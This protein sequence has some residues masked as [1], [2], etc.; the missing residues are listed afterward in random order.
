MVVD[1]EQQARYWSDSDDAHFRWQTRSG[2]FSDTERDL[3]LAAD[4]PTSGRLLEIGCGEGGNL[5]HLGARPGWLGI[6]FSPAK[7]QLAAAALPD[8]AF[9]R[10]DASHLPAADGSFDAVLI[11]D[12]LHHVPDRMAVVR[13]AA[14]V[15]R[16]GGTLGVIEPN[17]LCPL[18]TAQALLIPAERAALSSNAGLIEAE[19]SRAGLLDISLTRAQ[20]FPIARVV[21]H[22]AL[23]LAALSQRPT[24]AR[25]L[26]LTDTLLSRLIPKVA[27]MYLVLRARKA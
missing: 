20:P 2:Y 14:R 24:V 19:L 1:R 8:V 18:V 23:G 11:R 22:P 7:L 4:L 5:Y 3:V 17:G 10:A 21:T 26:T 9:A 15:L 16:P 27:W 12:L 13:E 25:L 6:D